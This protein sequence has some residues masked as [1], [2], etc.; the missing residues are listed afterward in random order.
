MIMGIRIKVITGFNDI[1]AL[2]IVVGRKGKMTL[3]GSKAIKE[4]QY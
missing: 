3:L 4:F 2:N 1:L